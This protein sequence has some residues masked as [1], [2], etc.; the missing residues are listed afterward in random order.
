[1]AADIVTSVSGTGVTGPANTASDGASCT[2]ASPSGVVLNADES[3]LYVADR[4]C[5]AASA[6]AAPLTC[7]HRLIIV[8][9]R[10]RWGA[11]RAAACPL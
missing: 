1:M 5:D 8:F 9:G 7:L 2:F 4:V 10:W 3:G 6:Q 11:V